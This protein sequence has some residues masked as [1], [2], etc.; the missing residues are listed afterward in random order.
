[1]PEEKRKAYER[2][3]DEVLRIGDFN[4]KREAMKRI[5]KKY[6]LEDGGG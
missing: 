5:E 1:M 6:G 4:E 3:I 2:E